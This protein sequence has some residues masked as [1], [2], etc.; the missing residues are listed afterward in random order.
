MGK[1]LVNK[2]SGRYSAGFRELNSLQ[3]TPCSIFYLQSFGLLLIY[4]YLHMKSGLLLRLPARLCFFLLFFF[5]AL[6]NW[7]T[8]YFSARPRFFFS[9]LKCHEFDI[10]DGKHHV[11]PSKIYLSCFGLRC[12]VPALR[13]EQQIFRLPG[14]GGYSTRPIGT[15]GSLIIW[16]ES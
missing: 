10:F 4:F 15:T 14:K 7:T 13:L 1:C 8:N 5:I 3:D 9:K 16:A 6:A 11:M 12:R 2:A